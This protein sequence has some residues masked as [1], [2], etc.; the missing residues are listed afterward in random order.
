MP[1]EINNQ[2]LKKELNEYLSTKKRALADVRLTRRVLSEACPLIE[3]RLGDPKYLRGFTHKGKQAFYNDESGYMR[4]H[5]YQEA[6][7]HFKSMG[8]KVLR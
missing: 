1:L 2:A 7:N 4:A 3:K 8:Y 5:S 6:R